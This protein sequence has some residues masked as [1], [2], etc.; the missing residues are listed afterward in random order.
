MRLTVGVSQR[1]AQDDPI[2]IMRFDTE[3]KFAPRRQN[4]R[5][6]LE[7]RREVV[8]IRKNVGGKYEVITRFDLGFTNKKSGDVGFN[9]PI[10]KAFRARLRQHSWR[11]IDAHKPIAMGP[12]WKRRESGAATEIEY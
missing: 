4:L 2:V 9:Q 1:L 8:E 6:G 5:H 7:H 3:S 11:K 12:E 10:V